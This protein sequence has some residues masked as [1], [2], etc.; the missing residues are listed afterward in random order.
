M[1]CSFLVL[2]LPTQAQSIEDV[3]KPVTRTYAMTNAT[4]ITQ[5]GQQID[6]ATIVVRDGLIQAIGTDVEVPPGAKVI[7]ADSLF[8]YPG[9]IDGLSNAGIPEPKNE[10][11]NSRRGR[12]DDVDPGNPPRELAGVTPEKQ[13]RDL[14]KHDDSS[15]EKL[16][17]VGFTAA[18]V[19][20]HGRM[21]PGKGSLIMLAGES[22]EDL[23]MAENISQFTQFSS[24]PRV[25]PATVIGVMAKFDELYRQARQMADHMEAYAK[26]P[27]G[28]D[29]PERDAA[30]EALIPVVR[31]DL[32]LFYKATDI[33]S[34]HRVLRMQEE[35][36]FD[37]VLV[38]TQEAWHVADMLADANIPV[39]V[40]LELPDAPEKKEKKK[41]DGE[42]E[43]MTEE[44]KKL[45]RRSQERLKEYESQAATLAKAGIAFGF[46]TVD[47]KPG[48]IRASLRRMIENG[49]TE[50]QALAALTTNPAQMFG[51]SNQLGTLEKGKIGNLVVSTSPY[52]EEDAK[53]KYVLIDGHL[54]EYEV[55]DKPKG[56]P[57]AKVNVSGKWTYTTESPRGSS[58]GYLTLI[59][60]NGDISGTYY[61]NMSQT[62]E[63]I[64]N[65]ELNGNE[66]T[67]DLPI[68]RGGQS[69]T[70]NFS[71]VFEGEKFD[72]SLRLGGFGTFDIEGSRNS[73]PE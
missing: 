60:N 45:K 49:L 57:N 44:M 72:G 73:D 16:R 42:A 34:I 48:D 38:G 43:E 5:P 35:L 3:L 25:F 18:H 51:V 4:I 69:I 30:I 39:I 6:K 67:F 28:M 68:N 20:P 46:T 71:L 54:F 2:S 15:L 66:L 7:E 65:A 1:V 29:R 59:D 21:L 23:L 19:V 58:S 22:G 55:K 36:G 61:S 47:A 8:I 10:S 14:L 53:V 27:S 31:G 9:F 40:N 17:E 32:P 50:E 56:D 13:V 26:N 11:E 70:M 41:E 62:E 37:V 24:A 64:R 12:R 63:E 33:K 52:F